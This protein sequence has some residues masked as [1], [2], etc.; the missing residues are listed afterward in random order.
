M[1]AYGTKGPLSHLPG[2]D[3]L[4]QGFTGICHVTGPKGGDPCRVGVPVVDLGTG[5]WAVIGIQAAL[6][7]RQV[8][9]CGGVVD[10][11]LFDTA[12]GWMTLA[13]S[14][15]MVTGK[16]PGRYGTRGPGALAPNQGFAAADGMIMITAGTDPQFT[17][18]AQ[19]L[20]CPQWA[21]DERFNSA[22]TRAENAVELCQQMEDVIATESRSVWMERLNEANVPNAPIHTPLETFEHPQT[23]ASGLLQGRR[24]RGG[25]ANRN[26]PDYRWQTL[27][28]SPSRPRTGRTQRTA[29]RAYPYRASGPRPSPRQSSQ[30]RSPSHMTR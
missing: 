18:L 20:G 2:Y 8:T 27:A 11:S 9:G 13:M 10:V 4:I 28:L 25:S 29:V 5:M 30:G 1:G 22:R 21:H 19:A 14:T 12:M 3:P 15:V 17:R 26:P 16:T 23:Q 7:R 6:M 24:R